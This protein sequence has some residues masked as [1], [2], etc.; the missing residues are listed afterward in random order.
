MMLHSY[1]FILLC[2]M[3]TWYAYLG[4]VLYIQF[5]FLGVWTLEQKGEKPNVSV[6]FDNARPTLT[7]MA[8]VALER[9]GKYLL[10]Q[11]CSFFFMD[12]FSTNWLCWFS[13]LLFFFF[14]SGIVKYVITQ[15]VDGLHSRSGFPRNRLS[16]LH[17]NMF[18]EECDKCGSQVSNTSIWLIWFVCLLLFFFTTVFGT[19]YNN[20]QVT[21]LII[22]IML[23]MKDEIRF[24]YICLISSIWTCL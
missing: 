21:P 12:F 1:N 6:T 23:D 2:F 7:H 13:W 5:L 11:K 4:I 24:T 8:L 18:V 17:G 19:I 10:F 3:H 16:E 9:A 20:I 15:N 22:Y 14:A